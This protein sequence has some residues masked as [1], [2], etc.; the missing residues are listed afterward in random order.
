MLLPSSEMDKMRVVAIPED[1]HE[2]E[3]YRH[4]TGVISQVEEANPD[5]DWD[6]IEEALNGH[7]FES[8]NFVLGPALD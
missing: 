2:Q 3:A 4:A 1:M 5:Y 7:G 8:I 6:D